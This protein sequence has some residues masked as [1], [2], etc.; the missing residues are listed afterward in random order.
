MQIAPK[1]GPD[2]LNPAKPGGFN[3]GQK[4]QDRRARAMNALLS[5]NAA[6]PV[7]NASAMTP[8]EH[9]AMQ[10][11]VNNGE[12]EEASRQSIVDET[13]PN[14]SSPA[15][16]TETKAKSAPEDSPL[17]QHYAILARKEKA[18]RAKV[19]A[20]E[21]A[22]R[23]KEAS[24][25]A[26]EEALKARELEYQSKYISKDRLSDPYS[27]LNTLTES[28]V[29][30]EQITEALLNP[31]QAT[32]NLALKQYQA[33]VEAELKSLREEQQKA[34]K[35]QED[36]Q[37]NQ[38]KQALNQIHFDVKAEVNTNPE[39]EM[40]KATGSSRDVV[41]LIERVYK[42]DKILLTVDEACKEVEDY[43]MNEAEKVFKVSK[44]QKRFQ[45]A[46]S[47]PAPA[48]KPGQSKEQLSQMKTLTNAVT[49]SKK[50]SAKERA[51]LAY[52]GK[53]K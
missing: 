44:L 41:D 40:I 47:A 8:I 31:Q 9:V 2:V 50:L 34:I 29:S 35:A 17:S 36:N 37:N 26:Q 28:G 30:Y 32:N 15:I 13:T 53:L 49:S 39:Y 16:A 45:P 27:A 4:D 43:L 22:I 51:I 19:A 18:L 38:Y 52:Q 25:K 42:T 6:P 10:Q 7:G 5:T 23:E 48:V 33:K 20:Q 21:S 14:A 24:I 3:Q 46:A 1:S 12:S 11:I